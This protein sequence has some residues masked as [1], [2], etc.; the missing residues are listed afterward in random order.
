MNRDP[1]LWKTVLRGTDNEIPDSELK[2]TETRSLLA[3]EQ[4]ASIML[5]FFLYSNN[6]DPILLS[7]L[8]REDHTNVKRFLTPDISQR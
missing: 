8:T 5:G 1:I 7:F 2:R 6:P 4:V 3:V